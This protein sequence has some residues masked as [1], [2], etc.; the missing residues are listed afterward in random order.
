MLKRKIQLG[1]EVRATHI[2]RQSPGCLL[3]STGCF[4]SAC[5]WPNNHHW[6]GKWKNPFFFS[7]LHGRQAHDVTLLEQITVKMFY[8]IFLDKYKV[9]YRQRNGTVGEETKECRAV[10]VSLYHKCHWV[11]TWVSCSV[12][13]DRGQIL[14]GQQASQRQPRHKL[15]NDSTHHPSGRWSTC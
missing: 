3:L 5:S 12:G 6:G 10:Q 14:S 4:H 13:P 2:R 11:L 9:S 8:W 1:L 15:I 7:K